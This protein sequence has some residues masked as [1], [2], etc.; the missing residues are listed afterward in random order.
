MT[1]KYSELDLLDI[2]QKKKQEIEEQEI[3]NKIKNAMNK[4]VIRNIKNLNPIPK[5]NKYTEDD[6]IY[7][8][9]NS[10]KPSPKKPSPKKLSPKKSNVTTL[11][12]GP[13]KKKHNESKNNSNRT[14]KVHPAPKGW[15]TPP[16]SVEHWN[17]RPKYT[18]NTN[19]TNN[20]PRGGKRTQ[21][22]SRKPRKL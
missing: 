12:F 9:Q 1:N 22:K 8:F 17:Q 14:S 7:N 3:I 10:K 5:T 15:T 20:K 19:N 2:S 11:F 18:N 4:N 13:K 6:D 21:K 16:G